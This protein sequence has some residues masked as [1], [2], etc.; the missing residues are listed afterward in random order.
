MKYQLLD[1]VK[2]HRIIVALRGVSPD[3]TAAAAKAL[4]E[5]G[6]R[7][8]EITFNQA[9]G[10]KLADTA[11]AI[12]SVRKEMG[13]RLLVGA[14][15]VM[16]REDLNAAY[17]AGADYILSPNL[18]HAVLERAKELGMGAIP[19]AM[20]PSEVADAYKSGADLVKLFPCDSLGLG[21]IKA[22]K[23]PISH[24]PLLAMGGVNIENIRDY[25]ALVEGVGI[26]SAI[27]RTD[28]ISQGRFEQL[29]A[30]AMRFTEQLREVEA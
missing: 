6:V 10:T 22:L 9:S 11:R 8:L 1:A 17:R 26:G 23:A 18:D 20:S 5:G 4:Y 2:E 29:T 30:L 27:A 24:V 13:D 25:L 12:E 16:S 7:M 15:T 19:G 21:Y 3:L 28:L 14:G